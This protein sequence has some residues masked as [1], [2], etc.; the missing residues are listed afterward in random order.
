MSRNR[1]VDG[2]ADFGNW[3]LA[4]AL[5]PG[6]D[7]AVEVK[8]DFV[9]VQGGDAEVAGDALEKRRIWRAD[10][11]YLAVEILGSD[12]E[13]GHHQSDLRFDVATDAMARG[14]GFPQVR[15]RFELRVVKHGAAHSGVGDHPELAAVE[16]NGDG[17]A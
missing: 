1:K 11:V 17:Q 8:G 5:T 14:G 4:A 6:K 12:A 13:A 3:A 10:D 16:I 7:A 2:V 9:G 15:G